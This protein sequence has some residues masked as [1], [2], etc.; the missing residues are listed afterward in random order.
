[1]DTYTLTDMSKGSTAM[2]DPMTPEEPKACRE[3]A[4]AGRVSGRLVKEG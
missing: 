3:R 2:S 4:E 1:M